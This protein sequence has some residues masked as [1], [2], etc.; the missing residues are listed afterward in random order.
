MM[1]NGAAPSVPIAPPPAAPLRDAGPSPSAAVT[2]DLTFLEP[3]SD[4]V[5]PDVEAKCSDGFCEIPA[6]CFIMGAPRGECGAG[7]LSNQQVQV[8]LTRPFLLGTH[9]VTYGEWLAEGFDEPARHYFPDGTSDCR[10]LDCPIS[11]VSLFDIVTFLNRY[12]EARGLR[13]CYVLEECEGTVGVGRVCS[14]AGADFSCTD[15]EGALDCKGFFSDEDTVYECEGYRLP[16]EAEWEYAARAGTRTAYWIGN[17]QYEPGE[18][19]TTSCLPHP[20]LVKVAW[21]QDNAEEIAHV[22]GELEPNPWGLF[23]ILGNVREQTTDLRNGLGFGEG[24]LVDPV[25]LWLTLRG[26]QDRNLMPESL[27]DSSS[28]ARDEGFLARG[29]DFSSASH[30]VTASKRVD[31]TDPMNGSS[32]RGF[33]IA[34]TLHAGTPE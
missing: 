21:F 7:A 16:T 29:G 2:G 10:D 27:P 19:S 1:G 31:A 11:N 23:D 3:T 6:G 33:R 28:S 5:H 26:E 8:T 32:L 34:R 20:D 14:G 4:C 9:E 17:I 25:G 15:G 30:R 18:I 12:S 13:P 24:P 22:V